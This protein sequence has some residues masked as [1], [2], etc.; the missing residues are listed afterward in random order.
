MPHS[1]PTEP[2]EPTEAVE[3]LDPDTGT[4]PGS[5]PAVA[6]PRPPLVL[7]VIALG[8]ALGA[9]A[10]YA[11]SLA[12][13]TPEGA[14]PSALLA[15][16]I[17]GS[18]LIGVLVPAVTDRAAHPLL[19]PFLGTGLLGGFTTFSV[20]AVDIERLIAEGRAMVG[21]GYATANLVGALFAVWA[22]SVLTRRVLKRSRRACGAGGRSAS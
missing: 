11:V 18:A 8:G 6:A 5:A 17:L 7:A 22:A 12:W 14:F 1:E 10:R 2:T 9:V 15:V 19:R 16:N 13:P 3:P 20:H 4:G 21:L